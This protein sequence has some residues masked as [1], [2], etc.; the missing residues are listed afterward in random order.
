MDQERSYIEIP[1]TLAQ[2]HTIFSILQ[3]ESIELWRK[4]VDWI[5]E[6]GGMVFLK[7]HPDYMNFFDNRKARYDY[8]IRRYLD[9]LDYVETRYR[10]QYWHVL[11]GELAEFWA[12][13]YP[14]IM[15]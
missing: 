12:A 6:Q 4:Q 13:R 14:T 1:Y 11:P 2:D 9:F 15:E 5:V 10:D 7:T 8:P 3:E